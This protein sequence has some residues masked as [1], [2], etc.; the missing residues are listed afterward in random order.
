MGQI[1]KQDLHKGPQYYFEA[2]I[3]HNS[4]PLVFQIEIPLKPSSVN[5]SFC[6]THK[7]E[8]RPQF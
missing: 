7:Y 8:E 5:L 4:S 1:S 2:E 3:P 6:K